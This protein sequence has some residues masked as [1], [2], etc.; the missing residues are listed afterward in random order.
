MQTW[1]AGPH[2][3]VLP[4]WCVHRD[5]RKIA[6]KRCSP[7]WALRIILGSH[8]S[9]HGAEYPG[10]PGRLPSPGAEDR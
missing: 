2:D 1:F 7:P 8:E 10:S 9:D 5:A 6:A 3:V 4:P